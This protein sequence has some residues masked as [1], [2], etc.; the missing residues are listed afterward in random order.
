MK[1]TYYHDGQGRPSNPFLSYRDWLTSPIFVFDC[2]RQ[3]ESLKTSS[4]DV[5]IEFETEA[6]VAASTTAYC[7]IIHDNIIQYNPLTSIITNH[8]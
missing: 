1:E 8:L 5:K 6:N 7:L 4:V 3:N 2:S